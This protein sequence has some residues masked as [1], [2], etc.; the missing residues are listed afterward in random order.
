MR[1]ESRWTAG[2][3]IAAFWIAPVRAG[4][5]F[6]TD[7]PEPVDYQHNEFYV[8]STLDRSYGADSTEGPAIE[9]NRGVVP[10]TQL[11]VVLP[12]SGSVP[13]G[14]GGGAFGLGDV[15]LGVKYRF[16]QE[17]G[18]WPQIGIFPMVEVATGSAARGLGNGRSWY[19]LPLWIQKSWGPWTSYGGAGIDINHAPGMRD[20]AFGGWLLQ[21]DFGPRWTLGGEL[22]RQN[23]M[24][25]GA[26][27]YTLV[28]LGGNYNFTPG[29]S[30]LFSGGR[31]VVG[32]RHTDAYL[33]LYWTWG[34]G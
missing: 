3:L 19:R 20:A 21:R 24:A 11:H 30:L 22:F 26:R 12:F 9:Y 18:R 28:N 4:P 16:L 14:G 23:A 17:R 5:P 29:F 1:T 8:F 32:E 33:G 10:N 13:A 6:F 7:D 31:S 27:D 15:E 34:P 25:I 2:L